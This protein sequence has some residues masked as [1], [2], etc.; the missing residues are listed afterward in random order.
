MKL[1]L[2][3]GHIVSSFNKLEDDLEVLIEN[4]VI[5]KVGKEIK[6]K[7]NSELFIFGI[8]R[9]SLMYSR[10][11]LL[12][13]YYEYKNINDSNKKVIVEQVS[14]KPL[15]IKEEDKGTIILNDK[16]FSINK[17]LNDL[18]GYNIIVN[19]NNMN[20]EEV[21]IILE[22]YKDDKLNKKIQVDE[23]FL[24]NKIIYKVGEK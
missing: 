23:Y 6:E 8:N 1:L 22:N 19:F 5:I 3:N 15:I 18:D 12:S 11:T 7:T 21:N 2:K 9:N 4:N 13:T 14:K 24:D 10:R 20:N 17:Y 16:I